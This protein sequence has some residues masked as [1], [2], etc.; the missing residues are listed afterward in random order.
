[1]NRTYLNVTT[2]MLHAFV[3][4]QLA[5]SERRAVEAYLAGN[6]DAAHL[7]ASWRQQTDAIKTLFD[8]VAAEPVPARLN[9]ARIDREVAADRALRW[10]N[11]AAA[12]VLVIIGGAAGWAGRDYFTPAEAA[13]DR[14]IEEAVGAHTLYVREKA[15]AV[16]VSADSPNL[17]KWLSTR[18]D[19]AFDAPDLT[20][21]GY[22][23][24]GG[25]LLPGYGEEHDAGP[26]AQL[27]Y[28]NESAE[29]LTLYVTGPLPD[30]KEVWVF[31]TVDGVDAYYWANQDVT[32]TIVAA[33]PEDE[34]RKLGKAVF[35]Q[36][37]RRPDSTWDSL[38]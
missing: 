25:R 4:G 30:K 9:V 33:L 11:L 19:V 27:M 8:P 6:S 20:A 13:S 26:A 15:H 31:R 24:I 16:E 18:I 34:V 2:D 37:T 1:M 10:R 36:L 29:R 22:R 3:D 35:E 14:L 32:C 28:E 5:D 12:I 17:M 21:Q 23:F 7:V 38:R